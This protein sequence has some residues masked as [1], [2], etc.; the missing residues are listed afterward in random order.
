MCERPPSSPRSLAATVTLHRCCETKLCVLGL[1]ADSPRGVDP[2]DANVAE[3]NT[4]LV[5]LVLA[6]AAF[7]S[8]VGC[9]GE[10]RQGALLHRGAH[11]GDG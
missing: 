11:N 2:D 5:L 6:R 1:T 4:L 9:V 8:P 10:L 7:V 3:E